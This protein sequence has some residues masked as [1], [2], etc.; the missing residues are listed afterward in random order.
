[1]TA[2]IVAALAFIGLNFYVFNYMG[3]DV[4]IPP[5]DSF[6]AFPD[7]LGGYACTQREKLEEKIIDRLGVTDYIVCNY[8]DE[9]ADKWAGFYV[10]YHEKQTRS[11][12]GK[13]TTIH[14]PEHCL[15]GSGWDIVA[16]DIVPV[17]GPSTM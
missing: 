13:E 10:G 15:P 3:R 14:P 11:D 6:T 2:R 5:R 4:V 8:V 16:S 9:E 1:M 17:A 12:E 7:T